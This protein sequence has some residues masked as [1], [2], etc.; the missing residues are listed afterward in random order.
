MIAN[1][2]GSVARRRGRSTTS[3]RSASRPTS[4]GADAGRSGAVLVGE[5]GAVPDPGAVAC[6]RRCSR[7]I[8]V[9]RRRAAHGL[10]GR[11]PLSCCAAASRP[12]P[13][14]SSAA[15]RY[16]LCRAAAPPLP[17]GRGAAG[18]AG[19]GRLD[20]RRVPAPPPLD[21]RASSAGSTRGSASTAR[22]STSSTGRCAPAG[23][24]GTS[25]RRSSATSTRRR[26]TRGG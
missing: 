7:P 12:S 10:P 13:A 24:G 20:A 21:A 8:G 11:H 14:R 5:P 16:A 2:P 25:R 26:P 9:R 6:L 17:P 23:S 15:R 4:T 18:R 19:A 3:G 22:T 1:V